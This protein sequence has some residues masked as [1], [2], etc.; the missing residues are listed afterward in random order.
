MRL[1]LEAEGTRLRGTMHTDA[2]PAA[3]T[4]FVEGGRLE[5]VT[6]SSALT[7]AQR[8]T[9]TGRVDNDMMVGDVDLGHFKRG[10][11]TAVRA[12]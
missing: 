9:F 8:L 10:A 7:G 11:W 2:G 3:L 4:G 1:E 6:N 5:F 12:R